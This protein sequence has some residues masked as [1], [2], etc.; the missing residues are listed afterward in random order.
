MALILGIDE[1]GRGSAIG[2]MVVCGYAVE[3]A[4]VGELASLGVADSKKL[5]PEQRE[6]IAGLITQAAA[7]YEVRILQAHEVNACLRRMGSKGINTLEAWVM[8]EIINRLKPRRVFIDSPERDVDTFRRK[9]I[10]KLSLGEVE[11]VCENKADEK[12]PVVSAAS[13]IAKVTRDR[14]VAKLRMEYGDFGTGYP[15]DPKTLEF[16]KTQLLAGKLPPIV[17]EGWKTVVK[18][19]QLRIEDFR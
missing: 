9:V 18:A 4:R 8:A 14:E 11:V 19:R 16:I 17:R 6:Y 15:S 12:Y 13:I 1:A 10:S 5:T 2:P 3:E 7:G